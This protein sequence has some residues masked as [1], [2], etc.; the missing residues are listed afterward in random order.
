MLVELQGEIQLLDGALA[1]LD[2]L[3]PVTA[4]VMRGSLHVVDGSLQVLDGDGDPRMLH[5]LLAHPLRSEGRRQRQDE[6][7]QGGENG[8]SELAGAAEAHGKSPLGSWVLGRS[9]LPRME[10]TN[11]RSPAARVHS[12]LRSGP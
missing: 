7:Q 4:E 1:G 9:L 8:E 6:E 2:R 12:L 5:L 10:H 11:A 3:H